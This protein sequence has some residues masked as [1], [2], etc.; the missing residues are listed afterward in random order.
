MWANI[1]AK[2]R[3][4]CVITDN[5]VDCHTGSGHAQYRRDQ[6]IGSRSIR[7]YYSHSRRDTG[8]WRSPYAEYRHRYSDS[9]GGCNVHGGSYQEVVMEVIVNAIAEKTS[10]LPNVSI[11]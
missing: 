7:A 11:T 3:R 2:S 4:A 1:V 10:D 9:Y 8:I 6:S 5:S